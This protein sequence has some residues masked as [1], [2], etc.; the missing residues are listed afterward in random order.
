MA[1]P[2][3]SDYVAHFTK[4]AIPCSGNQGTI[5]EGAL[6][7]LIQ[8]LT[9]TTILASSMP[10]TNKVAVCFTECPFYSMFD[11]KN[12]YSAYGVGFRKEAVFR[13]GGGPAI[14]LRQDIH[15]TQLN[16]FTMNSNNIVKGFHKDVYAF[17]TPFKPSY[18]SH[19]PICDYSYEREWRTPQNFTFSIDDISFVTVQ[20]YAEV[21][22]I[23]TVVPS[24]S[25]DKFLIFDIIEKIEKLWPTHK[26]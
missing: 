5:P 17:V 10:W 9:K 6:D 3:F 14:Y 20:S 24:I 26:I 13:V 7:R 23:A 12:N 21:S 11:H 18:G 8:I 19:S 25:E 16:N 1:R 2:D 4:N 15:D 22:K